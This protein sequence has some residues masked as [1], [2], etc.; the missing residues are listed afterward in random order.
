[1]QASCSQLHAN[2]LSEPPCRDSPAVL[3]WLPEPLVKSHN[4]C[5]ILDSP[6]CLPFSSV[7]C[8]ASASVADVLPSLLV[9]NAF[10]RGGSLAGWGL[11]L[12]PPPPLFLLIPD[13]SLYLIIG[14]SSITLPVASFLLKLSNLF[15]SLSTLL[16][17]LVDL[18]WS[19][20]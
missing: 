17:F 14:L 6:A 13:F 10:S 9:F 5:C 7:A 18:H 16:L 4:P 8:W 19:D 3:Q 1:M 15:F 20:Y 2:R 12:Q 11:V